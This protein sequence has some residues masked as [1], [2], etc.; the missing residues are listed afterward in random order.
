[1]KALIKTHAHMFCTPDGL[2]WTNSVYGYSFF[3]RYLEV[4]D[5]IRIV[6]RMKQIQ[7]NEVSN[8][9]LVSGDKIEFYPLPFY[10]GPWDYAKMHFKIQSNLERAI[11][12]CDCAILRIPD[13]IAFQLFK[14]LEKF[15]IPC[16]VEVV[17]HSWDLYSPG[18]IKTVLRPFLR[19]LWDNNQKYVCRKA[20]GVSYVT[21]DY[22]QKRYPSRIDRDSH[23]RFETDYTSADLDASF[24]YKSRIATDFKRNGILKLVHVSGISNTA[25][26]HFELLHALASVKKRGIN[27]EMKFVGGGTMLEH[28]KHLSEELDL[29]DRV[30]FLG[31]LSSYKEISKVLKDSDLF[32]FPTMTE[33][34]PRVLLEAMASGLPCIAS[35]V[36]GIPDLLSE[37]CLVRPKSI[38][39]LIDKIIKISS[40]REMMERE[41]VRNYERI[42][43]EYS[44]KLVQAERKEFYQR[45]RNQV[46]R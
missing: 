8:K 15:N 13:Q 32:V 22:I 17:A 7:Y 25:K 28:F 43:A 38:E 14:K 46:K 40:D 11:N 5:E 19:Y 34:L 21:K 35:N 29:S 27:F 2:V 41:S 42:V 36:G 9:L 33:G 16:A 3:K 31:N 37:E 18:T 23:R 24:F 44:P 1:M 6:T 12:G 26:G 20:D 30:A 45:L 39:A 10:H 4:F